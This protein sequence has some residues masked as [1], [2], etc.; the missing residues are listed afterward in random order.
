MRHSTARRRRAGGM[1]VRGK[2]TRHGR[3]GGARQRGGWAPLN[4][5]GW[6]SQAAGPV[7]CAWVGGEAGTWPGV[8]GSAGGDTKGATISN[9]YPLSPAGVGPPPAGAAT[10]N[11]RF[12]GFKALKGGKRR[13]R[14]GARGRRRTKVRRCGEL[15]GRSGS[16]GSRRRRRPRRSRRGGGLRPL[17]PQFVANSLWQ[18]GAAMKGLGAAWA[19]KP[20]PISVNPSVLRQ[21][22]D[23]NYTYLGSAPVDVEKIHLAA[24]DSVSRM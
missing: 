3:R 17:A 16:S 14:G 6:R 7:G 9:H 8:F 2:A 24:G 5:G 4:V 23:R 20:L 11:R 1:R 22:I 18:A 21:P 15:G 10:R 19:G 12:T 13:R